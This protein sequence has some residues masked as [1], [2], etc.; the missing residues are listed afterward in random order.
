M[1]KQITQLVD[2]LDGSVIEQGGE[3]IRF[4]LEGRS[5]E[6]DLSAANAERMRDAFAPYIRAGRGVGGSGR[7]GRSRSR[8]GSDLAAIRAW[9]QQNGY[10]VGDRGR[11]AAPVREAYERATS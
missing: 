11:I 6:I 9:A 2:D 8:G 1:K 5:Y 3:T 7:S 10:E 4:S